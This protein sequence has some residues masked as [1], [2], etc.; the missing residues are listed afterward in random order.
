M[1]GSYW[2]FCASKHSV[3]HRKSK[4]LIYCQNRCSDFDLPATYATA[5]LRVEHPRKVLPLVFPA[6]S[7]MTT[8]LILLSVLAFF[9]FAYRS[10][11]THESL[12]PATFNT[13]GIFSA[14]YL[15]N[16]GSIC[17]LSA[18]VMASFLHGSRLVRSE[19][20]RVASNL[21]V[22]IGEWQTHSRLFNIFYLRKG[23]VLSNNSH[24]DCLPCFVIV[25]C[26]QTVD[27]PLV[28]AEYLCAAMRSG[29]ERNWQLL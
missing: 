26:P 23:R 28:T 25:C 10:P 15:M 22:C 8:V 6:L 2:Q 13:I 21:V 11:Y 12:L 7:K 14:R 27:W 16:V 17:G 9:P 4:S 19:P 3:S 29:F 5:F 24:I 18:A 1:D 20:K